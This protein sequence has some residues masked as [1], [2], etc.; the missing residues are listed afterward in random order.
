[1]TDLSTTVF[2]SDR[3]SLRAFAA[4]DAAEAFAG[5]TPAIA[6]FMSWDPAPSFEAFDALWRRWQ[7]QM[8]AGT[9][10][11]LVLR[12]RS[13]NEFL[14][15]VGLHKVG[16]PEIEIGLWLK[17]A[18]H[19]CGYGREAVAAIVTWVSTHIGARAVIYAAAKENHRSRRLVEG[20]G[21]VIVGSRILKKTNGVVL[22]EVVYRISCAAPLTVE[23]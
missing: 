7:P 19:G 15:V 22:D 4:D 11:S 14:G 18:V 20:L 12:L 10:L 13:N 6:R 23:R 2:T 17:E 9:D 3:L 1:M 21:G 16:T 5:A 8:T